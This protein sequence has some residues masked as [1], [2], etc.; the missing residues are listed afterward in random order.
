MLRIVKDNAKSLHSPS[1]EVPLPLSA[2]DKAILT[3]MVDFLKAS[4]DPA[5]REKTPGLREGVG[6]SA[7]QIGA[8]K[9]L[10]AIYYPKDEEK[11]EYVH[12]EL[13]NPLIV[14]ASV[15]Q[16]YLEAGEGCLSVDKPHPGNVFRAYKVTVQAYD[17]IQGQPIAIKATGFEAIVLQ[18]EIDHLAGI[19]FYDRIDPVHPDQ[20]LDG[21]IAI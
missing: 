12:W 21:A 3:T 9:R 14:S 5:L 17:A 20:V 11:K 8:N 15:K 4:Q 2:G 6:L 18:H 10:L 13:A 16:C 1:K 19:L 7:P